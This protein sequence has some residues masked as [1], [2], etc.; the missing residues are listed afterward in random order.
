MCKSTQEAEPS[1]TVTSRDMFL[2]HR[3][4]VNAAWVH[5]PDHLG[6]PRETEKF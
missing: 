4:A 6:K 1:V 2:S 5:S 3:L